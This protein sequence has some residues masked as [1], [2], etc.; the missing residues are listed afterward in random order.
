MRII[1]SSRHILGSA[2]QALPK[3]KCEELRSICCRNPY[4]DELQAAESLLL[5]APPEP[6]DCVMTHVGVLR[7][8]P[9]AHNRREF[10]MAAIPGEKSVL[11]L[12]SHPGGLTFDEYLAVLRAHHMPKLLG[13]LKIHMMRVLGVR[14]WRV[15][16]PTPVPVYC[17]E[18]DRPARLKTAADLD[19]AVEDR[20]STMAEGARR[21]R[22]AL[23]GRWSRVTRH[24]TPRAPRR[25]ALRADRD[26]GRK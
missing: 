4:R 18:L 21:P 22:W 20:E 3:F 5:G 16:P 9:T 6:A 13:P 17:V 8:L 19:E 1:G 15:A 23:Q 25:P 10:Q 24:F 14:T 2:W 26:R 11:R 7:T 12:A